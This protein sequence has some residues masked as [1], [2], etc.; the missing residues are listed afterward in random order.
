MAALSLLVAKSIVWSLSLGSGTSG[1]VLAPLLMMGGAIGAL[2]GQVIPVGTPGLWAMI[3]MSAMMGGT[4]RSP[5]TAIIFTLELTYDV[6][7]VAGASHREHRLGAG[8]DSVAQAVDPYRKGRASRPPSDPRIRRRPLR[9]ASRERRSCS[10]SFL[11]STLRT[12]VRELGRPTFPGFKWFTERRALPIVDARNRVVGIITQGDYLKAVN[13]EGGLDLTVLEAGT[14]ELI[15]VAEDEV[16]RAA[17]VKLLAANVERLI[18]VEHGAA[19][20]DVWL[21]RPFYGHGCA[22][23]LVRR[24]EHPR[25]A[26]K[27]FRIER[28]LAE[29]LASTARPDRA[30]VRLVDTIAVRYSESMK[31]EA[32]LVTLLIQLIVIVL[33][34]RVAGMVGR[35]FGHPI[36][37]GE[38]LAGL[39]LGPSFLGKVPFRGVFAALFFRQA[40]LVRRIRSST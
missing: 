27:T 30:L 25:T 32:V 14:Q 21:S 39:F 35:R 33:I 28:D 1:G 5:F 31:N 8:H 38:I 10:R 36:V 23:A 40:D 17:V 37:V 18:V 15:T 26:Q 9:D 20:R 7:I 6:K 12:T 3:G 22:L 11:Q 24:G 19:A 29:P 4:M 13:V 16:V 2:A 34:A